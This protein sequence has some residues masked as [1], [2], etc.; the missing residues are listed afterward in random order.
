MAAR[1]EFV[2][3]YKNFIISKFRNTESVMKLC[4][5]ATYYVGYIPQR[6]HEIIPIGRPFRCS[7][8]GTTIP[9]YP[10]RGGGGR[11]S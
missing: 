10:Q 11:K 7:S 1:D 3:V 9:Q 8:G 4:Y 5:G 2:N 6:Y